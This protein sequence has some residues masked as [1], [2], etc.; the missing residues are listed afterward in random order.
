VTFLPFAVIIA[1]TVHEAGLCVVFIVPPF[2]LVV[3]LNQA[4]YEA[5]N[6]ILRVVFVIQTSEGGTNSGM[7]GERE[8][9]Q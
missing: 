7:S 1:S 9:P 6:Y 4:E 5:L 8:V 2:T 3:S